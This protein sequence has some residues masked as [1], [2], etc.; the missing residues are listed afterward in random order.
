MTDKK[1]AAE[2]ERFTT[3]LDSELLEKI[4]ILAIYEKCS[5]NVLMEEAI[6][7]LLKKYEDRKGKGA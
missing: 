3:T 4:K 2:K 5:T 6:E 7:D 1:P